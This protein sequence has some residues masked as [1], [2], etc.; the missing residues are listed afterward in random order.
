MRAWGPD[1]T[2]RILVLGAAGR[3]GH[4]AAEAFRDAGWQ[5]VSFVRPGASRRA[6]AGTEVVESEERAAVTQAAQG[7]DIILH[8][9]NTPYP[10]WERLALQHIYI[11]I[12]A[13]E[14]T[15]A[16]LMFPG[17]LYNYGAGMPEVLDETTPMQPTSHKGRLRVQ[18][19]QRLREAAER[20]MRAIVLRAGRLF[21][22]R[23]GLLVRPGD[24]P[25]DRTRGRVI[26]PGPLDTMHEWAYLPDLARAMVRL[27]QQR[28]TLPPFATFGFA[29][30]AV[31]GTELAAAMAA[32]VGRRLHVKRMG[33]WLLHTVGRLTAMGRELIEIEYLWRVPHRVSGAELEAEIGALPHTPL[34]AAVSDTLR[35]LEEAQKQS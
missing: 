28:A 19:E 14:A 6:P 9:F 35:R 21:R 34:E 8:A 5:V 20:G 1:V 10:Q 31:T 32:G 23:A 17:N 12:E 26:Y 27:A 22:R 13:A 16:T 18:M 2:G 3:L 29:G 30:H 11:A 15:G 4:A 33:W 25:G 7:A 24:R